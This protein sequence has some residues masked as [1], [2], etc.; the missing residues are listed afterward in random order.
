MREKKKIRFKEYYEIKDKMIESK[1]R[2]R[3]VYEDF[4]FNFVFEIYLLWVRVKEFFLN[5]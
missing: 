3:V 2:N 5:L 1:Q 4:V